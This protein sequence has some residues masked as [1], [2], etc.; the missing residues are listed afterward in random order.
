[1]YDI[2]LEENT[3]PSTL[4]LPMSAIDPDTPHTHLV[5]T[6]NSTTFPYFRIDPTTGEITTTGVPLNR[7]KMPVVVFPVYVTDGTNTAS[8]FVVVNVLDVNEPPYFPDS[9]YI[10]FVSENEPIGT[11]VRYITA[12][13]DDDPKLADGKNSRVSYA[14]DRSSG[15]PEVDADGELFT[16]DSTTGLLTT[17]AVFNLE[18][19]RR[20]LTII[21]RASDDGDPKLSSSTFVTIVVTDIS[22]FP[23]KFSQSG[24]V[25]EVSEDAVLGN[26]V[27]VIDC[28]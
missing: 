28:F 16:I 12:F 1:M 18:S 19:I 25:G 7:E 23:P 4:V 2:S 9:P 5:Y 15:E 26:A 20:N 24:F 13:D 14:I 10:G 22:E 6:L 17:T 8:A 3:P 21:V 11:H 27:V